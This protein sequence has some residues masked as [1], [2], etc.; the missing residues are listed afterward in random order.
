MKLT[1]IVELVDISR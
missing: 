1:Y